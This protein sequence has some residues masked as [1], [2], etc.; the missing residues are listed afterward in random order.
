M[1][2]QDADEWAVQLGHR[3]AETRHKLGLTVVA[4]AD[5]AGMSRVTWHRLER[6]HSASSLAN[7]AAALTVLGLPLADP[8]GQPSEVASQGGHAGWIPSRINPS[9]YPQLQALAWHVA[10]GATLTPVEALSIY[11]RNERHLDTSALNPE[12]QQLIADLRLAL[13]GVHPDV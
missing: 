4:A 13:E 7:F 6:G 8:T 5:A 12:E 2:A 9:D 10:K 1:N 11:E 3:I